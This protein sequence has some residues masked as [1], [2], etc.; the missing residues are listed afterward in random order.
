MPRRDRSSNAPQA[1]RHW[2]GPARGPWDHFAVSLAEANLEQASESARRRVALEPNAVEAHDDLGDVYRKQNRDDQAMVEFLVAT[3]LDPLDAGAYAAI[4]QIHLAAER[5]RDATE[6]LGKAVTLKPEQA[7]AHHALAT[8]LI[9]LG[10]EQDG[11]RQLEIA[12]RLERERLEAVQRDYQVNL[13]RIEAALR[14]DEGRFDEAARLWQQVADREPNAFSD[15][16]SLGKAL[17]K[18]GQH[19]AAIDAF[20]RA[21][22]SGRAIR[23]GLADDPAL[24]VAKTSPG[25]RRVRGAA[26]AASARARSRPMIAGILRAGVIAAIALVSISVAA[27]VQRRDAA[28]APPVSRRRY[29]RTYRAPGVWT[30]TTSTAR[31]PTASASR[32]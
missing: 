6:P 8:A 24:V 9:R 18:A 7:E 14:A 11:K 16:V 3:L 13:L 23:I 22:R 32:P 5:Y 28:P 31:A 1:S 2:P 21:L 26:R 10:I 4:G 17:G 20:Q 27:A 12:Q 25:A 29:S 30:S 19:A 15:H